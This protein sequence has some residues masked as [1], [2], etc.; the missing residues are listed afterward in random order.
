MLYRDCMEESINSVVQALIW[1]AS[2][3]QKAAMA[4]LPSRKDIATFALES[5]YA[6]L[7]EH[8]KEL[9]SQHE[10]AKDA[11]LVLEGT[12]SEFRDDIEK[13]TSEF[14]KERTNWELLVKEWRSQ[15]EYSLKKSGEWEARFL[16]A[17]Q[18]E[19]KESKTSLSALKQE[20]ESVHMTHGQTIKGY[21]SSNEKLKKR[22]DLGNI[23]SIESLQER[24]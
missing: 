3:S 24:I 23:R 13:E 16:V 8:K 15:N 1:K 4:H 14:E 12:I 17:R 11:R 22:I 5:S 9:L 18:R 10:K 20:M 21:V 19:N 2:N 6:S 7:E